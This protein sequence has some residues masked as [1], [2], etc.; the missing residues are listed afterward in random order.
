MSVKTR[1]LFRPGKL[2]TA[3]GS[4]L[5][6]SVVAA[7]LASADSATEERLKK[8]EA[9]LKS[10]R[11]QV[12]TEQ[13]DQVTK[14]VKIK[15]GTRFSYGGFVKADMMWT[16]HSDQQRAGN[17]GD[18]F[19]V[20]STIATGPES[21]DGDLVFDAHAKTSRFWLKTVTETEHGTITGYI[22]NDFNSGADE[23]I[24]NQAS[25][26]L[27]HVFLKW[28]KDDSEIL[29]G[30][31][32]GTFFNV[33]ALPEAV[34]FVGPTS[35][36]LFNRQMQLRYTKKLGG[37][38]S[39]MVSLENPSS[40]LDTEDASVVAANNRFDDSTLPDIVG[41]Y[42]GKSGGFSYSVAGV[43]RDIAYK[44]G[45]MDDSTLGFAVS[46]SGKVALSGKDNIKFALNHGTLG[47]YIALDAFGDGVIEADGD[48]ELRDVTGGYI[49][50]QHFW[51]DKTRS[52]FSY[53]A[54][55]ADNP[56]SGPDTLTES[57]ANFNANIM[58]SPVPKLTFGTEL[59]LAER[60]TEAGSH[61][62]L[63]RLQ[64][65]SKWVF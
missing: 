42:N 21:S 2:T 34:D 33:G 32:W 41:R 63:T 18:D 30:Q 16:Q 28:N 45:D 12:A 57:V 17:V 38:T 44:S 9:E 54:S 25:T 37:G 60:E 27:R 24:T 48:I 51:N 22:E 40:D 50:Y 23:R 62:D 52:T 6:A 13:K 58:Y 61:G 19:L 55:V 47:R 3:I 39:Y 64:F 8:L 15:K 1:P 43:L 14:G 46:F 5:L 4:C 10:L 7:P 11:E 35:G 20:P 26:G 56:D 59:I 53:A 49:A 36:T 29:A 31:T 65:M